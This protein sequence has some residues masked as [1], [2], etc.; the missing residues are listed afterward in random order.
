V[1]AHVV[2]GALVLA[3]C[4]SNVRVPLPDLGGART[5][6]FVIREGPGTQ[7]RAFDPAVLA[8]EAFGLPLDAAVELYGFGDDLASLRLDPAPAVVSAASCTIDRLSTAAADV[9]LCLD[10]E[11]FALCEPE[12][13]LVARRPYRGEPCFRWSVKD[14]LGEIDFDLG[15]NQDTGLGATGAIAITSERVLLAQLTPGPDPGS[16]DTLIEVLDTAIVRT[17]SLPISFRPGTFS[18]LWR[19]GARRDARS[20]WITSSRGAV[21]KVSIVALPPDGQDPAVGPLP[22][23]SIA[24]MAT[25]PGDPEGMLAVT[26]FCAVVRREGA[27]WRALSSPIDGAGLTVFDPSAPCAGQIEWLAPDEAIAVGVATGPSPRSDDALAAALRQVVRIRGDDVAAE[28]V[29]WPADRPAGLLTAITAYVAS[30]GARVELATGVSRVGT[31]IGD[32][33]HHWF[34]RDPRR[35]GT[36]VRIDDP[37][38]VIATAIVRLTAFGDGAL[39]VGGFEQAFSD[40]HWRNAPDAALSQRSGRGIGDARVHDR[41]ASDGHG[42]YVA[43]SF[44]PNPFKRDRTRFIWRKRR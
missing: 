29:P 22:R 18:G 42:G 35:G 20:A 19:G 11:T 31:S 24:S 2:I 27:E 23:G 21:Q 5:A 38:E 26:T 43:A 30:D 39:G 3:A 1:R 40:E 13:T 6:L 14:G 36:W 44:V 9:K 4:S 16:F 15:P 25:S 37:D 41:V 17:S 33:R 32:V 7:I 28:P 12:E 10:G 34:V 8:T